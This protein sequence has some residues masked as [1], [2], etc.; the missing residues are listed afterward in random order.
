MAREL[1]RS[2]AVLV[3]DQ[4]TRGLDVAAVEDVWNK[5]RDAADRGIGVL[6]NSSDLDEV[7]QLATR[8]V[9][10]V[11]GQIAGEVEPGAVDA[12]ALGLL[13]GGAGRHWAA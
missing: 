5:I 6:L 4:P 12:E 11:R 13:M 1:S 7:L 3:A 9:V 2:P 10:I 8:V